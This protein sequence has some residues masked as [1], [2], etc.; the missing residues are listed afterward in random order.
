MRTVVVSPSRFEADVTPPGDKSI[1]HR[2][3]LL[4]A[5]AV[6]DAHITGFPRGRDTLATLACLR[7][8]GVR[9]TEERRSAEQQAEAA[10][11][12]T[13]YPVAMGLTEGQAAVAVPTMQVNTWATPPV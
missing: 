5:A 8:L 12:P 10:A 9:I 2:A 11:A 4:N 3:L 7:A 13:G 1:A 6:G